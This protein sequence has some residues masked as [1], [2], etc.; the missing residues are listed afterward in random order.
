MPMNKRSH[1]GENNRL[2]RFLE[3]AHSRVRWRQH[4]TH[5]RYQTL[6][7]DTQT[8]R[9]LPRLSQSYRIGTPHDSQ[10]TAYWQHLEGSEQLYLGL[11]C[12]R[13]PFARSSMDT[14]E[15][16]VTDDFVSPLQRRLAVET[17]QQYQWPTRHGI[18]LFPG[19]FLRNSTAT[20]KKI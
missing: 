6:A 1:L 5:P 17:S 13:S 3:R 14:N 11:W 2:R 15:R 18:F 7:H 4:D 9:W 19:P 8:R 20:Q 16:E 10:K 12:H